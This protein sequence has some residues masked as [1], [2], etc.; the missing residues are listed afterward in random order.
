MVVMSS[1]KKLRK[2]LAR[3]ALK[4]EYRRLA[5]SSRREGGEVRVLKRVAKAWHGEVPSTETIVLRREAEACIRK[6]SQ[7]R[8]QRA[9]HLRHVHLARAFLKGVPYA[10][11]ESM[12]DLHNSGW[13]GPD[14]DYIVDIIR[15]Q[16][17]LT[18]TIGRNEV[19]AWLRR[20]PAYTA[21]EVLLF[22]AAAPL[23][24]YEITEFG[25]GN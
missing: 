7:D 6:L 23:Q 13:R 14:A 24:Q 25:I 8:Q 12:P 21:H 19:Q 15:G 3:T 16:C 4:T 18:E 1:L 9:L 2:N 20:N 22:L 17:A 5:T 10:A 11:V